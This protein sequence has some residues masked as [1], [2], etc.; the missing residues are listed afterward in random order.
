VEAAQNFFR[1]LSSFFF[2]LSPELPLYTVVFSHYL[3]F[4]RLFPALLDRAIVLGSDST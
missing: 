3:A 4:V 1:D 2:H